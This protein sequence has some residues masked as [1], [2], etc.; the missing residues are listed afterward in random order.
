MSSWIGIRRNSS[1]KTPSKSVYLSSLS[2]KSPSSPRLLMTKSVSVSR[3]CLTLHGTAKINHIHRCRCMFDWH[4]VTH[5]LMLALSTK[6]WFPCTH[7]THSWCKYVSCIQFVCIRIHS[8]DSLFKAPSSHSTSVLS[9]EVPSRTITT[10]SLFVFVESA[11]A[12]QQDK[13]HKKK[14]YASHY[15]KH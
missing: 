9:A 11:L 8:F 6:H 1:F 12:K 3:T 10:E 15:T 14:V 5:T 7:P 4:I 13:S 2:T